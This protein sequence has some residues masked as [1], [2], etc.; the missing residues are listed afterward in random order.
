ML[1]EFL[2]QFFEFAVRTAGL[3]GLLWVM[4]KLQ[5]FNRRYEFRFRKLLLAAAFVSALDRV[6]YAGHFLAVPVLWVSVKKITHADYVE[7]FLTIATACALVFA[8]SWFLLGPQMRALRTRIQD[9][10]IVELIRLPRRFRPGADNGTN[11]EVLQ[12]NLSGLQTNLPAEPAEVLPAKPV[13]AVYKFIAVKG[14]TRNAANSST[15]IQAGS[16]LYTV[17]L[18]EAV[19]VQTPDGPASVR[20][21]GLDTNSVTLEI[22]GEPARFLVR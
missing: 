10:N 15:T 22:N 12:T 2:F 7:T 21:A 14:V 16:R 9:I 17:F 5:R 8:G 3:L 11:L 1:A 6:P 13:G 18:E 19:M 4:V 20:F